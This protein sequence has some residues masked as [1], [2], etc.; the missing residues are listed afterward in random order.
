MSLALLLYWVLFRS[1]RVRLYF[2]L[3]LSLCVLTLIHPIFTLVALCLIF[4][5][6]QIVEAMKTD[7]LS[8]DR[9]ALLIIVMA[10][11]TIGLGKYGQSLAIALWGQEDW[12]VS[13]LLMPLGI[14]YFIF[15]LVQYVFDHVRGVLYENSFLKL[16]AFV[17]FIPTFAAG[18]IETF[19]G[20]FTKRCQA[21][22]RTLF[23]TGLR[24]IALGYFKKVFIVNFVFDG[25]FFGN[26]IA[27]VSDGNFAWSEYHP[28][29]P[30]AYVIIAFTRAYFDLSAYSDLAI[31][32]SR[33][34]GFRI[35]ENF[36]KALWQPNLAEFWRSWHISLS[37]WCR[38]NVY[39]PIFGL[40]R[41]SWLGIYATMLTMG[42]WHYVNLNWII[43]GFYH[44]AGLVVLSQWEKYKKLRRKTRL[45]AGKPVPEGYEKF[46]AWLGYPATFLFVALGYSFISTKTFIEGI[47][48]FL[49]SLRGPIVW[50]TGILS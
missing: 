4:I 17:M 8:G 29:R 1:D 48:I 23:Y 12:V 22:Q 35:M 31:G 28:L 24:R 18:P 2:I 13:H 21:F 36:D 25:V 19:Q 9:A 11:V 30:L 49:L 42:I 10:V 5:A 40:T 26:F 45:K 34:F 15:R 20:F 7:R 41:K 27:M 46:T 6:Y 43:W 47:N 50:L 37:N 33:L 16:A 44:G 38:N 14:S 32:F 39:F 3:I